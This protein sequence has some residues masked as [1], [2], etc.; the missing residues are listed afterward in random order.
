MPGVSEA[1]RSPDLRALVESFARAH[2]AI[3]DRLAGEG[4]DPDVARLVDGFEFLAARV[5]RVLDATS[6]RAAIHF[7]ELIAPEIL[8]SFPSATILELAPRPSRAPARVEVAAGAEFDGVEV[9]GTRCRFRANAPFAIVPFRV[10]D[11]RSSWDPSRGGMLTVT[12]GAVAS[13]SP[14]AR[15]PVAALFPL[16]LHVSG[17]P[18]AASALLAWIHRHV[19]DVELE[20]GGETRSL[21][22]AALRPW[23]LAREEALLPQEHLEHPGLRLLREAMILPE[24]LA[25]FELAPELAGRAPLASHDRVELRLRADVALPSG[26]QVTRDRVRLN[27]VPVINVFEGTAEPFRPSLERPSEV[28]RA[29][30]LAPSHGG[31]Y[32]VRSVTAR[33]R[34]G[35]TARVARMEDFD[36][37]SG[38]GAP[39][40]LPDAFYTVR[41]ADSAVAAGSDVELALGAPADARNLPDVDVLSIELWATNGAHTAALGIGDVRLPAHSTPAGVDFRN[42]VA[43]SPYRPAP[44][45][46]ELVWR[47]LAAC[48]LSARSLAHRDALRALVHLSNL[49]PLADAQAARAHAARL[50]AILE[51]TATKASDVL[52]EARVRGHDVAVRLADAGFDGDGD[53]F[54]YGAVLARLFAHEASVNAFVRTTVTLAETGATFRFPALHGDRIL[55]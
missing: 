45:G 30:G 48:A 5:E 42:I 7:G 23:G 15:A 53:A 17:E 34:G 25:F 8:R 44:A 20:A 1:P 47:T 38:P 55:G 36:G 35:R 16:R 37:A 51:V 49:H 2:P 32:A 4:G 9:G 24:K 14:P 6:A 46:G 11:A 40:F 13:G 54:L 26:L 12:L 31:V 41:R 27:C 33:L 28:L 43:V 10:E 3:A 22:K 52:G 21:G 50:A 39:G 29:A 19:V 18:N